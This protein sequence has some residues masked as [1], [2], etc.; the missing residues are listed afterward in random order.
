MPDGGK[1]IVNAN[2]KDELATIEIID[3]GVGIPK[4]EIPHIFDP[5][6]TSKE[7]GQGTGLGLS[8][9]HGIAEDMKGSIEVESQV[10]K[11]SCFRLNIPLANKQKK[12]A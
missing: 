3:S 11:G 1:L 6:Y 9:C 10:G 4:D 8:I 12:S 5:F 2:V 7:E